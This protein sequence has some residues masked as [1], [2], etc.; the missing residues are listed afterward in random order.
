[1]NPIRKWRIKR[2]REVGNGFTIKIVAGLVGVSPARFASW[3]KGEHFPR[4]CNL[5][6]LARMMQIGPNELSR[7]LREWQE[8][9]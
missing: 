6:R 9:K 2:R 7:R 8:A 1:M 4:W 3:E 5:T